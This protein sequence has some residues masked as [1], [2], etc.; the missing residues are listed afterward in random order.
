MLKILY[1]DPFLVAIDKPSGLLVH[2]T[3]IAKDKLTCMNMLRNQ[4]KR[5]VY[6]IHRLDRGTS[7]VLLFGLS[8]Q[9][10]A[11]MAKLFSSR[12]LQKTY[13]AIVRGY[14][15][16]EGSIEKGV[17]EDDIRAEVDAVT[18]FRT[19]KKIELPFKVSRYDTTRYSLV[20]LRPQ[21]GRQHQLRKHL[22]HLRH[23]IIGDV[24]YG[25]GEHNRFFRSQFKI[26]RLLLHSFSLEFQHPEGGA[27]IKIKAPLPEEFQTL[28]KN[29]NWD[30]AEY[31][32]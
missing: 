8:S 28:A 11:K 10:A 32:S 23:P 5:W 7:G 4:L 29:F 19:L 6:P 1:Q 26:R 21:T 15:P 31:E 12:D 18:L 3:E 20:E 24:T 14:T 9:D 2:P 22:E 30:L 17:R 25:D 27:Q 16:E 13:L